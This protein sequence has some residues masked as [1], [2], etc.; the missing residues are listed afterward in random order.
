MLYAI[1]GHAHIVQT[2]QKI[3]TLLIQR[4]SPDRLQWLEHTIHLSQSDYSER[5]FLTAFSLLPRQLGKDDLQLTPLEYLHLSSLIPRQPHWIPQHWTLEHLGRSL[6]LLSQF[7][8]R[9]EPLFAQLYGIGSVSEQVALLQALPL[10]PESDR[11]LYWAQEGFRSHITAV[12]NA[13]AL[14]N[15]YP[16]EYFD[17]TTWNQLVLK[18]MFVGSPL[19]LIWGL[20][21]RANVTLSR[22]S[23]DY[24]HER[25]AAGRTVTPEFWR[26]VAPFM[27]QAHC[28]DLQMALQRCNGIGQLAVGLLCFQSMVPEISNLLMDYPDVYRQL[29]SGLITWEY[30]Y[31]HRLDPLVDGN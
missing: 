11:Y 9:L 17:M 6:L 27:D 15:P 28:S 20:D 2:Y 1:V 4:L 26:V 21:D 24:L 5:F 31:Q 3:Y 22:M 25:W 7:P 23:M 10:L 29:E 13:I 19:H 30:I 8:D 18:A 16:A 14:N 12:F